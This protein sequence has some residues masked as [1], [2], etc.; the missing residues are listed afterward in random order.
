MNFESSSLVVNDRGSQGST[1][2]KMQGEPRVMTCTRLEP[3]IENSIPCCGESPGRSFVIIKGVRGQG[4]CGVSRMAKNFVPHLH[5]IGW[6]YNNKI[7]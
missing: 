1:P 2:Q 3:I 6:S 7:K 5:K 4:S